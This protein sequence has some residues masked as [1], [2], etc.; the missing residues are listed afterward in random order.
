MTSGKPL[1]LPTFG[2]APKQ[3]DQLWMSTFLSLLARRISLLAGPNTIQTQILLQSPNGTVYAVTVD[4]SGNL[5][6]TV[7]TR[8]TV[9][10]PI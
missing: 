5:V 9:Q 4:D 2:A 1:P 7:A 8:G 10:P 3:Y 6:R